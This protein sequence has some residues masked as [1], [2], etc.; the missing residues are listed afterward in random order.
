MVGSCA[1]VPLSDASI[2]VVVSFETLQHHDRH[3]EMMRKVKRVLRPGGLLIIST[4]DK[5]HYSIEP[6][7]KNEFHVRE[8][9]LELV[10]SFR[11]CSSRPLH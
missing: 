10:P 6:D 5:Y 9:F 4:P 2:D 3:D 11:T 1:E 7:H 8:L